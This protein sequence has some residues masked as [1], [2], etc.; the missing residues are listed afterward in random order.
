M[1]DVEAAAPV[2]GGTTA[3]WT[4]VVRGLERFAPP[5]RTIREAAEL[6][7]MGGPV[8]DRWPEPR[9]E[10]PGWRCLPGV[11][12]CGRL[13]SVRSNRRGDRRHAGTPPGR[14][15]EHRDPESPRPASRPHR[16]C[17]RPERAGRSGFCRTRG[18]GSVRHTGPPAGRSDLGT[19]TSPGGLALGC[20]LGG[21][22]PGRPWFR[23]RHAAG[24]RLPKQLQTHTPRFGGGC[25]TLTAVASIGSA[26][27]LRA[28]LRR[29]AR[30]L[31][32]RY[33]S[34]V[35]WS[36]RTGVSTRSA[37]VP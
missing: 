3:G 10:R 23:R 37:R 33:S 29:P 35:G 19:A 14:R 12:V 20:A 8:A 32:A 15:Y 21:R 31:T 25:G 30:A 26:C 13:R 36:A 28:R 17:D 27:A 7:G 24:P 34:A 16:V 2:A 6:P 22:R 5:A 18:S 11:S 9:A 4:P 1:H